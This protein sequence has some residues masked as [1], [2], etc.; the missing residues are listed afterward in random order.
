MRNRI[1]KGFSLLEVLIS[2]S[3][4][5]IVL[6]AIDNGVWQSF[7]ATALAIR[8]EKAYQYALSAGMRAS[9]VPGFDVESARQE[10]AHLFPYG[11]LQLSHQRGELIIRLS[12]GGL[13]INQC[14]YAKIA[15]AGCVYI[16]V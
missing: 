12:Y 5:S 13:P 8:Y 11:K 6:L 15:Q 2:L 9:L 3:I 7:Q 14:F 1:P 4:I 10:A 16:H